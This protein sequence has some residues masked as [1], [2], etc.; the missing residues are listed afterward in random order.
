MENTLLNDVLDR[1]DA[2]TTLPSGT[3]DL[4]LAALMGEVEEALVGRPV[5]SRE[6]ESPEPP[7]PAHAWVRSISV[8]GFRGIGPPARL[9]LIPGPGLTLVVG[10]NGSGKS[11]FS[12]AFETLLTGNS[13]RWSSKKS[14]IWQDGWRNLH[15][16]ETAISA[17]LT[18]EGRGGK[19]RIER[20]WSAEHQL[21][22]GTASIHY[23]SGA[24][25]PLTDLG[26]AQS[27]V[28]WRPFLS[29]EELGSLLEQGPSKL[30]DALGAIL[31]LE[32]LVDAADR[33][34]AARLERER[35]AKAVKADLKTLLA[36]LQTS[37]DD[38]AAA[39]LE[40]LGK[41]TWDLARAEA[42]LTSAPAPDDDSGSVLERLHSMSRLTGP[43]RATTLELSLSIRRALAALR[44][45]HDTE[46][47]R[48]L[49]VAALLRQAIDLHRDEGDQLC[50]VCKQGRLDREWLDGAE[51]TAT[52]LEEQ[53]RAVASA[54]K[55]RDEVLSSA[56]TLIRSSTLGLDGAKALG[57]EAALVSDAE[58]AVARWQ[59]LVALSRSTEPDDFEL[60][61]Q[62]PI[63]ADRLE[64]ALEPI[65]KAAA[66]RLGDFEDRW[67]PLAQ[68]LMAWL[69]GAR[70]IEKEKERV[71][72]LKKAETW[73]REMTTA[74]HNE[75][76]EP[77]RDQVKALWALLRTRS[78]VEVEDIAFAGRATR[79]RVELEVTVDGTEGAALGVM[80]QGELHALA[81]CLFLPRATD[82]GS[83]FRF[84]FIDDP[85]QSMDPSRVE[86]LARALDQVARERQVVVF[87]HDDRLPEA[88]RRLEIEATVLEVQRR[89]ESRV[90]V[91]RVKH[92]V[93]RYF[94]DARALARTPEVTPG[95]AE[96]VIPGLCRQALEAAC[97]EVTRRRRLGK[98]ESHDA[99]EEL[100]RSNPK[101]V[102]RLAL[103]LFDDAER[104]GEVMAR[105]NQRWSPRAGDAIK[106]CNKG[107]HGTAV[108]AD[109]ALIRE[110]E[111]VA[112]DL[113]KAA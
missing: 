104:A 19:T 113:L 27:L 12:E 105:V 100:L 55:R 6:P 90:E 43:E 9:D 33:L 1:L 72:L 82:D 103:A 31:G 79:R 89:T 51:T 99:V 92:P 69:P 75:R 22:D 32:D 68:A 49:K 13:Y 14:K 76:F 74:L 63:R 17:E 84:L 107:A 53:A 42:Q 5:A 62:L 67:R 29:Y 39:C 20:S 2:E 56:R 78:H 112:K 34:K 48:G 73:L 23:T 87:T 28:T 54:E 11:S 8:R 18:I 108:R 97:L 88:V 25:R 36:R 45:L 110:I 47:A 30:F 70:Q 94:A 16:N 81:L 80:S 109:E 21:P 86:G 38:R 60:A 111:K 95:V 57:I 35:S 10:R 83:P 61:D 65:R 50:P 93:D 85:V 41:R 64:E 7:P 106:A 15:D 37:D 96:R 66:A 44:Q 40:A 3:D 26:W 77:I 24:P 98:G 58:D 59:E 4:I 46:A 101:L 71:A 102:P 91:R 52:E